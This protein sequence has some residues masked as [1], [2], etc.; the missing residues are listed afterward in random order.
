MK[1]K[2]IKEMQEQMKKKEEEDLV[3]ELTFH[4][5]IISKSKEHRKVDDLMNW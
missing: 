5:Q 2:K 1:E 4:P 3:K